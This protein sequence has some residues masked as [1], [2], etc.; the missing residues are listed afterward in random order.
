MLSRPITGDNT[1]PE[2]EVVY[3]QGDEKIDDPGWKFLLRPVGDKPCYQVHIDTLFPKSD[4]R[5]DPAAA[6]YIG[7]FAYQLI[8]RLSRRV[9]EEQTGLQ[10][11][12][13]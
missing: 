3:T 1:L 10:R 13:Y 2:I 7:D 6:A 11:N 4:R 8:N 5:L 9:T 12:S